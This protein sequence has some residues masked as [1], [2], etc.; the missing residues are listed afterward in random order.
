MGA[1]AVS[2]RN[3]G[4]ILIILSA[5][6]FSFM[7]AFV[8][9]AGELP[10]MQKVFFR[11]FVALFFAVGVMIK[12]KI[13]FR[14]QNRKNSAVLF[15]R[16]FAGS[17]GMIANFY[18][19]DVLVLSD[20]SIL[21]KMS[22]F[23]CVIFSF[24]F[25]KEKLKLFNILTISGAFIGALFV[26][27]PTFANAELFASVVGFLGGMGAGLAYT[28]VRYLGENGEKGPMIVAYFSGFSCLITLPWLIF[29]Y[30]HMQWWQVLCLIGA[31]FGA[32]GGQFAITA[33]Y[34][35]APAKEISV[36]DYTQI[37]F[38]SALGLL[39]F[40][41]IPDIWSILGYGIIISMALVVFLR[42]NK[43]ERNVNTEAEVP[44]TLQQ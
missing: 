37:I 33:A 11:N 44:D 35:N 27:K 40:G 38:T 6:S 24:I 30:H 16:A 31:G 17:L 42:N 13:P 20:A 8:R 1:K 3:K 34:S 14:C 7:F 2:K 23:F 43:K 41:Q 15:V 10:T 29:G 9:L 22:P 18:A 21:N 4:I 32:A 26:I 25:L 39:M 28:C 12:N 19:I 5:F 36:F